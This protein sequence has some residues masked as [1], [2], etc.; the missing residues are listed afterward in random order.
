M[1]EEGNPKDAYEMHTTRHMKRLIYRDFTISTKYPNNIVLVKKLGVCVVHD[2]NRDTDSDS[3]QVLLSPFVKQDDF[4]QGTPCNSSDFSIFMVSGGIDA[5]K[6]QKV[7]ANDIVN[8]FVCLM[9][10]KS[11][12]LDN[13]QNNAL[14]QPAHPSTVAIANLD[15]KKT[16]WVCIPLM[17]ALFQ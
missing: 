4:F 15:K 7:N 8:Q 17:H 16:A 2:M 13:Q 1:G 11:V 3:F 6:R 5:T 12:S 9:Y 10:E 14:E